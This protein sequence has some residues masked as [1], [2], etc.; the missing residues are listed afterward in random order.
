[1]ELE[2]GVTEVIY[3]TEPKENDT[4]QDDGYWWDP[5]YLQLTWCGRDEWRFEMGRGELA[6]P[7]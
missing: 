6:I 3:T 4:S 2:R 1:M 5:M 7:K